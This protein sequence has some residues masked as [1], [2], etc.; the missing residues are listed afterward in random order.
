MCAGIDHS[1]ANGTSWFVS[2]S[3]NIRQDYGRDDSD[4]RQQFYMGGAV[5]L[6]YGIGVNPFLSARSGR[7]F[8]ITTGTDLTATRSTT[9][10]PRS[11]PICRVLQWCVPR[12]ATLTLTRCRRRRSSLTTTVAGR[13]LYGLIFR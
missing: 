10:A 7:P 9:I 4:T 8:N 6:P 3:Y 2:N 13:L 11:R 12:T 1:D 5:N